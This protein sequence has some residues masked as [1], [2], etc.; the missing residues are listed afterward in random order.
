MGALNSEFNADFKSVRTK[1]DGFKESYELLFK[2]IQKIPNCYKLEVKILSK[3]VIRY[4]YDMQCVYLKIKPFLFDDNYTYICD[5]NLRQYSKIADNN[6]NIKFP[7]DIS[8]FI[9][10]ATIDI[11]SSHIHNIKIPCEYY[12]NILFNT[13]VLNLSFRMDEHVGPELNEEIHQL[14]NPFLAYLKTF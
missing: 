6:S 2:E 1:V 10:T 5:L 13:E 4:Q 3:K 7:K 12:K 11:Q 14:H 9:T 8:H